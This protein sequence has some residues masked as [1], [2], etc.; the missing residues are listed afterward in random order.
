MLLQNSAKGKFTSEATSRT[1]VEI[2]SAVKSGGQDVLNVANL[3][4]FGVVNSGVDKGKS[5]LIE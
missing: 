3:V 1:N 5:I 2:H 4:D